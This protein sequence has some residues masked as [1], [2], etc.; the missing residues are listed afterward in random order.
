MNIITVTPNPALDLHYGIGTLR[1]GKENTVSR[2]EAYA[3]GKSVNISRALT[4]NGIGNTAFLL[5]GKEN[6]GWFEEKLR[7]DGIVYEAIPVPGRV[8]ENVTIHEDDQ[9]ET[10]I[11]L[12]TFSVSPALFDKLYR[13]LRGRV[14]PDTFVTVSG[15]MPRGI[16]SGDALRFLKKLKKITP[17][18]IVDSASLTA[19]DIKEVK[20]FLIKP[21]EQ[22]IAAFTGGMIPDPATAEGIGVIAGTAASLVEDG[23]GNV[24][25]TLGGEGAVFACSDGIYRATA[26]RITAVSTVGAGDS[27]IAG[28]LAGI[29]RGEDTEGIL[30]TALSFGSAACLREGT[31]A[32]LP[33]DA[34]A[35]RGEITVTKID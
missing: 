7:E 31:S 18:L 12:D 24:L 23:I 6:G 19:D 5:L 2:V 21:N 4:A 34:A 11:S 14:T 17:Y 27:T 28:F 15:R 9:R 26:P 22:E 3:G 33:E 32:P 35:L 8:R 10:R 16:G 30:K 1:L 25:V 13:R 29:A 20:P